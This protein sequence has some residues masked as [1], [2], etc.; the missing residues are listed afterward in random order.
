MK[1]ILL[2]TALSF[3]ASSFC[4]AMHKKHY[5]NLWD[6]LAEQEEDE[7]LIGEMRT[8][9][10]RIKNS[11]Y[12]KDVIEITD[13]LE[14]LQEF[15][16]QDMRQAPYPC[17]PLTKKVH[18]MTANG[19]VSVSSRPDNLE[20]MN[21][22]EKVACHGGGDRSSKKWCV[23]AEI[24]KD[25]IG[26]MLMNKMEVNYENYRLFIRARIGGMEELKELDYIFEAP[27]S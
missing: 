21:V 20:L 18:K 17:Q 13:C 16:H 24:L 12:K 22:I 2:I 6:K 15:C 8:V 1:K 27:Q 23:R 19:D 9:A 11:F 25:F 7:R 3:A 4:L 5:K 10:D 26:S 14:E